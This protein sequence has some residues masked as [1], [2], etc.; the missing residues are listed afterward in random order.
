MLVAIEYLL[1]G[2][3]ERLQE[4]AFCFGLVAA[5]FLFCHKILTFTRYVA[6]TFL[7]PSSSSDLY[8]GGVL[9]HFH[10]PLAVEIMNH[11]FGS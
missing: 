3:P 7:Q 11:T 6:A 4:M 2:P 5:V 10:S 9:L 8:H 1:S